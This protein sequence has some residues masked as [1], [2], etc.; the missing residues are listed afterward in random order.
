VRCRYSCIPLR[1]HRGIARVAK[2]GDTFETW[3]NF[4]Q[5]F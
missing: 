1:S 3:N 2:N 5:Q 4:T